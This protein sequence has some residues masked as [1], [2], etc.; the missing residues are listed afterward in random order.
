[1]V[2]ITSVPRMTDVGHRGGSIIYFLR[3]SDPIEDHSNECITCNPIDALKLIMDHG[4]P[5]TL[6]DYKSERRRERWGYFLMPFFTI[7]SIVVS[8]GMLMFFGK[9]CQ[10]RIPADAPL[11][12]SPLFKQYH[13]PKT[14]ESGTQGSSPATDAPGEKSKGTS[15]HQ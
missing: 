1:L 4:P 13:Q 14:Q 12:T 6:E 2:C 5:K 7:A 8:V 9:A 11:R 10:D 15:R 3:P